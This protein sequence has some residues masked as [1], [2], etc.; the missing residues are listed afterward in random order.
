MECR[1][2]APPIVSIFRYS[3][4]PDSYGKEFDSAT[5]LMKRYQRVQPNSRRLAVV[6]RQPHRCGPMLPSVATLGLPLQ[7][8]SARRRCFLPGSSAPI[9]FSV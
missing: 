3:I 7:C 2:I 6:N 8:F 4:F 1:N 5:S 9:L